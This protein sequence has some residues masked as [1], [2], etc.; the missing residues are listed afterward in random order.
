MLGRDSYLLTDQYA[1]ENFFSFI[2]ESFPEQRV[3][4]M[5]GFSEE[6]AKSLTG[7]K[8]IVIGTYLALMIHPYVNDDDMVV[9]SSEENLSLLPDSVKVIRNDIS[10]KA[11]LTM[12]ILLNALD[13]NFEVNHDCKV[14]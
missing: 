1:N 12:N 7:K 11:N 13:R 3:I 14:R 4:T 10:K 6:Q 5:S 9:I 8:I 2:T